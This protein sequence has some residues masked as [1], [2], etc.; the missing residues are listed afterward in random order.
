MWLFD[1]I[2]WHIVG[3]TWL[4]TLAVLPNGHRC[5]HDSWS[6]LQS[7]VMDRTTLRSAG[8]CWSLSL[9]SRGEREGPP[10]VARQLVSGFTQRQST[11]T[12]TLTSMVN[13]AWMIH[14]TSMAL[15]CEKKPEWLE[16]IHTCTGRTSK[17][18]TEKLQPRFKPHNL[19]A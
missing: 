12:V 13:L 1:L 7:W 16:K 14:L 8:V 9:L 15:D 18:N 10:W 2:M 17:I 3:P 6:N 4:F 5:S 11:L 19:L